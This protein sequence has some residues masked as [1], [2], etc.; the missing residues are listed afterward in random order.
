[1]RFVGVEVTHGLTFG[2]AQ[3][4]AY[5]RAAA[6]NKLTHHS[7]CYQE[8]K[9]PIAFDARSSRERATQPEPRQRITL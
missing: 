2:W 9:E 6:K 3:E 4:M 1:M 7:R 5:A 8:H